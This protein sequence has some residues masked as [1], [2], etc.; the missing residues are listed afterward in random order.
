M[1][2]ET[3]LTF[4]KNASGRIEPG[5][6]RLVGHCLTYCGTKAPLKVGTAKIIIVIVLKCYSLVL[7]LC[8]ASKNA[9]ES[10]NS[11]DLDQRS[12]L[13]WVYTVCSD[14]FIPFLRIINYFDIN[15]SFSTPV[16]LVCLLLLK[17]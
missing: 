2:N 7:H 15:R 5:T 9:N 11:V 8:N 10:A 4:D 12:S 1:C 13:I 16:I 6:T 14:L 17:T 3:R